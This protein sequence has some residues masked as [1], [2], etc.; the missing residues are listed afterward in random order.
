[1]VSYVKL[2]EAFFVYW[3]DHKSPFPAV[4]VLQACATCSQNYIIIVIGLSHFFRCDQSLIY[5]SPPLFM[6][7]TYLPVLGSATHIMK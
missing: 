1:M 5:P 3:F 2:N 6:W 7:L 4:T